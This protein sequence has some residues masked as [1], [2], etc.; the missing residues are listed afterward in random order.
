MKKLLMAVA[1]GLA[2]AGCR[3]VTV[4]N[5]G[6]GKGWK[7]TVM[8][9]MMKSEA[10]NINA[11]V[12]PDGTIEFDMGGLR[13]SPSEEFAKSLMTFAYIARM[14]AAGF[15]G[16][17]VPSDAGM[18]GTAGKAVK[19]EKAENAVGADCADGACVKK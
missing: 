8:S 12:G 5:N 11:K 1:C 13:S 9:N 3:T 7:V 14:A 2:V 17:P 16:M 6:D 4:E 18:A 15:A 10:D 19:A